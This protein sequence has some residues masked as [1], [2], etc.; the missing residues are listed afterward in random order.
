MAVQEDDVNFYVR[1]IP[2]KIQAETCKYQDR[3]DFS[4]RDLSCG[5]G[6]TIFDKW[7]ESENGCFQKYNAW[8]NHTSQKNGLDGMR[9]KL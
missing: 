2:E 1:S 9:R 8:H 3:N 5:N 6:R 7:D 4:M